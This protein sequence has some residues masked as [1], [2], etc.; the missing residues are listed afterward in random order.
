[1]YT[2]AVGVETDG[3]ALEKPS[4]P[5]KGF[6]PGGSSRALSFLHQPKTMRYVGGGLG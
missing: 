3:R 6:P 2:V 1:M 4:A 5:E